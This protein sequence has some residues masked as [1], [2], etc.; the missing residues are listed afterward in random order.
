MAKRQPPKQPAQPLRP[1]PFKRECPH[2]HQ[3]MHLVRVVG[4]PLT[5]VKFLGTIV[6]CCYECRQIFI[7]EPV[8]ET[9]P[10]LG[11]ANFRRP[12]E[13]VDY[14]LLIE[15]YRDFY[16]YVESF[17]AFLAQSS[18]YPRI[19]EQAVHLLSA[20]YVF[21]AQVKKQLE[22]QLPPQPPPTVP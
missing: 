17:L 21:L 4:E 3:H 14:A 7:T 1:E 2:C 20:T 15:L 19:T 6:Y 12:I 16:L 8:A 5:N 10:Y 13:L 11:R 18:R 9:I 22:E